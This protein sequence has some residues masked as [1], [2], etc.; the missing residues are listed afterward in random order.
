MI[1]RYYGKSAAPFFVY[2]V[3]K[4]I[5]S[6]PIS[7]WYLCMRKYAARIDAAARVFGGGGGA[8]HA[9]VLPRLT[10]QISSERRAKGEGR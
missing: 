3:D 9:K 8:S 10:R 5:L 7:A 6:P 4:K 2:R 1:L